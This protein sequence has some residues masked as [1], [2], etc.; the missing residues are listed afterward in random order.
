MST[1]SIAPLRPCFSEKAGQFLTGIRVLFSPS[2]NNLCNVGSDASYTPRTF[3]ASIS[4]EMRVESMSKA[5]A[6]S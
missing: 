5:L 3:N 4:P 2:V 6:W 1:I